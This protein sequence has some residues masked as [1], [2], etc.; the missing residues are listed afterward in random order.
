LIAFL[1]VSEGEKYPAPEKL[2]PSLALYWSVLAKY[3]KDN[4]D[5]ESLERILGSVTELTAYFNW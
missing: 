5:N 2:T 1:K 3:F 4:D